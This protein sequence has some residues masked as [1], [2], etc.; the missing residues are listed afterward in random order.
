MEQRG[1]SESNENLVLVIAISGHNWLSLIVYMCLI[2]IICMRNGLQ[3]RGVLESNANLA[4][5]I[6]QTGNF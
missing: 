2:F 5:F 6:D 4:F 1:L 3:Q